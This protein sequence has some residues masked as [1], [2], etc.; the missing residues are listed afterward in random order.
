MDVIE[1][2]WKHAL[3]SAFACQ[4]VAEALNLTLKDDAFSLGLFHDIGK[5]LLIQII[6]EMETK[7]KFSDEVDMDDLVNTLSAHH[8]KFGFSLLERW[9]FSDQCVQAA[10]YCD[11]LKAADPISKEL[12]IVH[13]ANYW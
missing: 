9:G 5:L 10:R 4:S 8:S 3:S 1:R 12:I 6:S 11:D 2:L 7:S 13:F